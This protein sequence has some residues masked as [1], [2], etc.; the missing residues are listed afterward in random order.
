M[1]KKLTLLVL[2]LMCLLVLAGCGCE[3][4][5]IEA[6]CVNPATCSKCDATEGSP[7][8]HTWEAATC[9]TAKTCEICGVTEGEALGHDWQEA[10]VEAP[11]TCKVCGETEGDPLTPPFLE[12]DSY[13]NVK[14]I[15]MENM[16]DYN[17]EFEYD[18]ESDLLYI[19]LD[20]PEG[21][22]YALVSAPAV[23]ADSWAVVVDNFCNLSDVAHTAFVNE[24]YDTG[25]ALM[26]ISDANSDNILLSCL[27]GVVIYN[28]MDDLN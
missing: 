14:R 18:A 27:N 28:V 10:T 23:M 25:C 16:G 20:A 8:G 7:K 9:T 21:A 24:G 19:Y 3:H 1:K 11:K 17:P 5:W 15:I 4:E 13:K 2:A 26:M 6:D 12:S 22:A